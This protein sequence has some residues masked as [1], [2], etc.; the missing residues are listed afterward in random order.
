MDCVVT[1]WGKSI[2]SGDLTD[3]LLQSRV[4]IHENSRFNE[5][6]IKCY[7]E[8]KYILF[9][10]RCTSMYGEFVKIHKGHICAGR[11]D[12]RG[13]TCVVGIMFMNHEK[14]FNKTQNLELSNF[15]ERKLKLNTKLLSFN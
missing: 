4:P 7:Y 6:Y 9:I 2:M 13:N 3:I 10:F 5:F 8:K 11:M 12:G 1:G 15:I 14:I